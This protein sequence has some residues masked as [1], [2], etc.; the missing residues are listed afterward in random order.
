VS[1]VASAIA[2]DRLAAVPEQS[3]PEAWIGGA[4]LLLVGEK[5]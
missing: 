1:P 5:E 2:A 3:S 4:T